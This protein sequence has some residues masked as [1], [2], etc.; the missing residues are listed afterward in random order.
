[1]QSDNQSVRN[2]FKKRLKIS[3]KK[4]VYNIYLFVYLTQI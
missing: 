3:Y 2:Y 1:M 4:F